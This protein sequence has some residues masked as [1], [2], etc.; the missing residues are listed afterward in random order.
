MRALAGTLAVGLLVPGCG[1]DSPGTGPGGDHD[2]GVDS[3]A[4]GGTGCAPGEQRLEGGGWQ[5]AGGPPGGCGEGFESNDAGGCDAAMP[6]Q[7]C[8]PGLFALPG[9]KTC[10]EV[11]P[12]GSGR[13]ADDLPDEPGTQFVDASFT[14]TSDGSEAQP[15]KTIQEGVD[16]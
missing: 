12:C 16:A 2:A 9:E 8:G 14:G 4:D 15:W 5:P 7:P 6:D 3:G 10:H 13:W 1:E 11:A